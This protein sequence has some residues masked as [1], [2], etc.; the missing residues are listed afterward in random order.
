MYSIFT[1][2]NFNGFW[3]IEVTKIRLQFTP[4]RKL[5]LNPHFVYIARSY[6]F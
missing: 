4:Y 5:V 3:Y 6:A 1:D 2:G